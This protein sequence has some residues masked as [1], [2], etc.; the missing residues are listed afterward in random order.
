LAKA[1]SH[2]AADGLG[3]GWIVKKG[4]WAANQPRAFFFRCYSSKFIGN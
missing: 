3:T 2:P 4:E 1:I